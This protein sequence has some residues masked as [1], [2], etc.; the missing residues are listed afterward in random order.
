[1]TETIRCCSCGK[2]PHRLRFEKKGRK[3]YRC[4]ACGIETQHPMPTLAEL[5]AYY[6]S[7]FEDGMY[8]DFTAADAM[9]RMTARQR[10]GEIRRSF[11]PAGRCLD[12]GCAN[13]VFV[14]TLEEEFGDKVQTEGVELSERAVAEGRQ[15]GLTLHVGTM[16][17]V[18]G[19]EKFDVITA[20]DVL[21]H[22]I[23]PA[24]FLTQLT[25]RLAPGGRLVIT[26]PNT[27]GI[28]RRLMGRRWYFYI[29]EEHLT[30]F[31]RTNLPRFVRRFGLDV[32][33]VGA[34]Y[35]PMTYDYALT[36]F[37]EFNPLIYQVLKAGSIAVPG[38]LRRRPIPLP[39]GETRLVARKL[40]R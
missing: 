35:K 14:A 23:D 25:D 31:D 4:E 26:V 40:V 18:P 1:M 39:I 10:L 27:G 30:Y 22:V 33:D 6:E 17:D 38:P 34:T 15:R 12:V 21:E 8:A 19:D 7:S 36:Q 13:G 3:F 29:P 20:F 32:V 9:K 37:A 11:E 2:T 24:E 16:A 28:V 5:A